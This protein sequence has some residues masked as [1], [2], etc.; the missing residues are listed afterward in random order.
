[1]GVSVS[2]ARSR[3]DRWPPRSRLNRLDPTPFLLPI[4]HLAKPHEFAPHLTALDVGPPRALDPVSHLRQPPV[5][6][7]VAGIDAYDR[8]RR[9]SNSTRNAF[10]NSLD[11]LATCP[12]IN[13]RETQVASTN[14]ER[15]DIKQLTE[16][17]G[18]AQTE[19]ASREKQ[20]RK[21]LRAE[22]ERRVAADGYKMADLFPELGAGASSGARRKRPA[23]YRDPQNP[24]RPGAT[25]DGPRSGCRR[26][27]TN[28][29][30]TWPPSSRSRCI[31]STL[32]LSQRARGKSGERRGQVEAVP[33]GGA[34]RTPRT[35]EIPLNRGKRPGSD[36]RES[37]VLRDQGTN[38]IR[39]EMHG[40]G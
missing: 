34:A 19:M 3:Q 32:E 25:L 39:A 11:R 1:M 26:S 35:P 6:P 17:L 14:L 31:R 24:I 22:L 13:N 40:K 28:A 15:L 8:A 27:S 7:R 20:G 18:K 37:R 10:P 5:S 12:S 29:A 38:Q 23:K 9:C 2:G 33:K 30:S 4:D 16:L 21:D 36:A